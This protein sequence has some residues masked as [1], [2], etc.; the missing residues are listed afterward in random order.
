MANEANKVIVP[1]EVAEAIEHFRTKGAS[2]FA[3]TRLVHGAIHSE[4]EMTIKRWALGFKSSGLDELMRALINGYEVEKSA[5]ELQTEREAELSRKY[6][7]YKRHRSRA[8][9]YNYYYYDGIMDGIYR[10]LITI[11]IKIEGVNA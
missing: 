3:I 7:E 1:K 4:P 6:Q 11:G 8:D 5:E 10:A 2:N 9:G